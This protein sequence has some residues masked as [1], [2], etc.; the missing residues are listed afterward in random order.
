MPGF[1]LKFLLFSLVLCWSGV[2]ARAQSPLAGDIISNRASVSFFI[3][4][5]SVAFD[6]NEVREAGNRGQ[7]LIVSGCLPQRFR[8]DLPKLI[9]FHIFRP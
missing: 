5:Q 6:S 4:E 2:F 9:N 1:R 3:G 8:D 7:A